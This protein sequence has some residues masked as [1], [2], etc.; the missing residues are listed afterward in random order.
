MAEKR[1]ITS[2]KEE[3]KKIK[4]HI[5]PSNLKVNKVYHIPPVIS[6]ERMDIMVLGLEN[7][8]IRFKRVDDTTDVGEKKM[9]KTSILS[10]F[11]VS[12]RKF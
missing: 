9:H 10:R 11:I 1:T 4:G 7:D 2:C 8:F 3:L 12:K 6:L 5:E